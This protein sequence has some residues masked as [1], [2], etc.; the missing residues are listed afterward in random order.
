VGRRP[1]TAGRVTT[2]GTESTE[3]KVKYHIFPGM[4]F[5]NFANITDNKKNYIYSRL[6][7]VKNS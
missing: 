1:F 2:E 6:F 7:V 5:A 4:I 3:G